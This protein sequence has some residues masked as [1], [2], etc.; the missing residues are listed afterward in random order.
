MPLRLGEGTRAGKSGS[1]QES[2]II[3][4]NGVGNREAASILPRRLMGRQRFRGIQVGEDSVVVHGDFQQHFLIIADQVPGAHVAGDSR[5]GG[6]K[7]SVPQNGVAALALE[8]GYADCVAV[9]GGER[10]DQ[11][12]D[13]IRRNARHVA[14]AHHGAVHIRGQHGEPVAQGCTEPLGKIRIQRDSPLKIR[15]GIIEALVFHAFFCPLPQAVKR[16]R[17]HIRL[18]FRHGKFLPIASA[19][20]RFAGTPSMPPGGFHRR[21]SCIS[22]LGERRYAWAP[23]HRS[24]H[25]DPVRRAP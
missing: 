22:L 25:S 11:L 15:Q 4:G 1:G 17:F 16:Y 20:G 3:I 5:H 12:I 9:I 13:M 7:A 10:A 23:R 2:R 6:E 8:G 14:Q 19:V 18:S 21:F 24:L